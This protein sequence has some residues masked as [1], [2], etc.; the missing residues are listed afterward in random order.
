MSMIKKL[1]IFLVVSALIL[2]YMNFTSLSFADTSED[3]TL[4]ATLTVN[5]YVDTSIDSTSITFGALDPATSDNAA[6]DD[7][8]TLTNTA[9]SNTAI[10][11][12]LNNSNMTTGVYYMPFYN[13]SVAIADASASGTNM[14]GSTYMNG[15]TA[16]LG[17]V[18]DLAVS[19]TVG[20][21]F[22]HDVP[23]GQTAGAYTANVTIHSVQDGVAP[24]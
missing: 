1:G 20:F 2:T 5:A 13:L 7:P 14:N 4:G 9:N 6:T 23:A 3:S 22:W 12:Y 21:Y 18:E 16:N 19:G 11:V 17:F 15:T 24:Q 8:I 10:D